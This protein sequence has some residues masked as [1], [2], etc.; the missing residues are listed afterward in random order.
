MLSI[1]NKSNVLMK[2][3]I[4][5]ILYIFLFVGCLS[6]TNSNSQNTTQPD[7]QEIY[8][9]GDDNVL[10]DG[11]TLSFAKIVA[12]N[13]GVNLVDKSYTGFQGGAAAA[14]NNVL[15][16]MNSKL[17]DLSKS[18]IV[19]VFAGNYDVLWYGGTSP[20]GQ[21]EGYFEDIVDMVNQKSAKLIIVIPP[22]IPAAI[23]NR[24]FTN[25]PSSYQNSCGIYGNGCAIGFT[26]LQTQILGGV[27]LNKAYV[28]YSRSYI[29]EDS[30]LFQTNRP[31]LNQTAHN[32]IAQLVEVLIRCNKSASNQSECWQ[33]FTPSW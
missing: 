8:I 32:Y 26:D 24:A 3:I 11:I 23:F 17:Q 15:G 4:L 9:I 21:I 28:V 13:L 29:S 12:N 30:G 20:A 16:N 19:L 22:K 18:D 31:L 2:N 1:R 25:E 10:D 27:N 33:G 5:F 7:T 14:V 6:K